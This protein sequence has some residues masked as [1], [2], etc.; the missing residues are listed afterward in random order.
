VAIITNVQLFLFAEMFA[1]CVS[2]LQREER[3]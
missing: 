3:R 2:Y 1:L